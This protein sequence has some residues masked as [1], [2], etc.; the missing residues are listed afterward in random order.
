[1]TA[2]KWC[3]L[4]RS[5]GNRKHG[6]RKRGTETTP[7]SWRTGPHHVRPGAPTTTKTTDDCDEV[8][9]PGAP[10]RSLYGKL[11]GPRLLSSFFNRAGLRKIRRQGIL[12]F[13]VPSAEQRSK[14]YEKLAGP[15]WFW[16]FFDRAPEDSSAKD[17]GVRSSFG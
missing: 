5:C 10:P 7:R 14:K 2:T 1:M 3:T 17:F 8:P 13:V 12:S 16:Y 4:A 9:H 6:C 11:V 15:R